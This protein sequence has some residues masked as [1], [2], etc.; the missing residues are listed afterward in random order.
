MWESVGSINKQPKRWEHDLRLV[1]E[2]GGLG[3][4]YS[5]ICLGILKNKNQKCKLCST[6]KKM[7][8]VWGKKE[9]KIILYERKK[10]Y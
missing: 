2:H 5:F 3:A 4:K 1:A 7:I 9:G 10:K 6:P 8:F